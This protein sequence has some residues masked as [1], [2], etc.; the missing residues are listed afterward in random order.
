MA[1]KTPTYRN[2]PTPEGL[3]KIEEGNLEYFEP[4]VYSNINTGVLEEYLDEKDR[5][6]GFTRSIWRWKSVLFGFLL[7]AMFT[8]IIEYV[9]LKVGLAI[10]GAWYVAYIFGLA[11]RWPSTEMNIST[12][13]ATAATHMCTGFIFTF[14]AMYLLAMSPAYAVGYDPVTGHEIYLIKA[15]PP[16]AVPLVAAMFSGFLGTAYFLLFRRIWLIDDPLPMPG[17]EASIKLL[18]IAD[19]LHKGGTTEIK[20]S[21]RLMV[22]W[23]FATIIFV[24]IRDWPF[25]K[26]KVNG[27]V[28]Q[29]SILDKL[30]GPSGYYGGGIVQQPLKDSTYTRLGIGLEPILISLGW[31]MRLRI[32]FLFCAGSL[33]VWLAIIPLAVYMH[34]PVF[35]TLPD[36][37]YYVDIMDFA[38][39]GAAMI[40]F[41]K[42][43]R[44][45]AIGTILGG[46]LTALVRM[47]PA[48]V[49]VGKD[50]KR[51]FSGGSA[52]D[53]VEG[54]GW[55]EWPLLHIPLLAI[56]TFA[57]VFI[58]FSLG[59]YPIHANFVFAIVLVASTFF[60][61]AIAVKVMGEVGTEP[62]SGTSFIVLLALIGLFMGMGMPKEQTAIMAIIG[63][64][65]FGSAIS[66]SGSITGEFKAGL[67]A[68]TRPY[69]LMKAQLWAVVIGAVPAVIGAVFLSEGLATGRIPLPAPQA[70]AFATLLLVL[71]GG[72]T[73]SQLIM[74]IGAGICIGVFMDLLTGMGT[75][76]GLGMYLQLPMT[77]PALLGGAAREYWQKQYLE[78]PAKREAWDE[79][80]KTLKLLKS[81]M[82]ATGLLIGASVMGTIVAIYM[83][84]GG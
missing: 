26:E 31:F 54:K 19:D 41:A 21:I 59:G 55:Y 39:H 80:T 18:Q 66:M 75:A 29:E 71:L 33:L 70:N 2:P 1:V 35:V 63:T 12:L 73:Q 48:F 56:V 40:A 42:I 53:Y 37:S 13:A 10:G 34:T 69:H 17:I 16:I 62:V 51:A 3:R 78:I 76:F 7:G 81:Y 24:I 60:I 84:F 82:A 68:G 6:D 61:G 4:E 22:I 25:W 11:F 44:M 9:G 23:T 32:A 64:S 36:G 30:L 65:V 15:I 79:T 57:A 8:V 72:Q 83:V 27:V 49:R 58:I 47:A 38:G 20:E 46:G 74:F 45:I 52:G 14:P 67:Y 50:V 28:V 77:L 43:S 5:R